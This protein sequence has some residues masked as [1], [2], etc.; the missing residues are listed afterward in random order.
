MPLKILNIEIMK[1]TEKICMI[2]VPRLKLF[3]KFGKEDFFK[4]PA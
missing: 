2:I 4:L 1:N 3:N